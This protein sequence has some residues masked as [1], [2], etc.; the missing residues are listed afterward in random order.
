MNGLMQAMADGVVPGNQSLD[1]VD[2]A[3]REFAP[4]IFTDAPIR[5][6]RLGLRAG[7]VTSLGFGHVGS[8]VCLVHP[9]YF[10]RM[11]GE[12][13]R[14][15]YARRVGERTRKATQRLQAALAGHAPMYVRRTDRPFKGREG[16]IGHL[17]HEAQS[18]TDLSVRLDPHTGLY[19][20]SIP[21]REE[22]RPS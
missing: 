17:E 6:G 9:F 22:R 19:A 13:E 4:M 10:W 20:P 5:V 16:T 7:L 8:L 11:L 2:P 1:D 3:M 12:R 14:A 18:L 21:R 15:D